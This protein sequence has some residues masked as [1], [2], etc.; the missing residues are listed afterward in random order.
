LI[1]PLTEQHA[2]LL[3]RQSRL[4]VAFLLDLIAISRGNSDLL[5]SLLIATIIQAN[6]EAISRRPEV[7][8][9]FAQ[10][11]ALPPDEMRRPVSVSALANSLKLPF[12]TVRRRV[13]R[14]VRQ[15]T[16]TQVDGGLI[17][18]A[19]VLAAP[20]FYAAALGGFER[21][22]AYYNQLSDLKLLGDLPTPTD[23]ISAGAFPVRAVARLA[24]TY[25][26]RAVEATGAG[27]DL[28]DGLILLEMYRS[29]VE[30][31]P[32]DREI[33]P[34]GAVLAPT[35]VAALAARV[36]VPSETVR[37]RVAG[38][39]D[40]GICTRVRGGVVITARGLS[41]PALQSAIGSSA[42]NVPRLFGPLAQ[43]GVL[44]IWDGFRL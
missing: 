37:R 1:E 10:S 29:N 30:A 14:L 17:V 34:H 13:S 12:E 9:A 44:R 33:T 32:V 23:P 26:L 39:M 15:G 35:A 28:L 22:R 27:G 24:G 40:N 19:A 38:L 36:G 43:L 16:Y 7:H 31:W 21:L 42:S 41:E 2:A 4:A 8:A 5:D 11:D 18:P 25:V 20:E 6:V 3:G